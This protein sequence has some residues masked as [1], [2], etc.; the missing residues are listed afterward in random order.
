M[1]LT[2]FHTLKAIVDEREKAKELKDCYMRIRQKVE[3]P[4]AFDLKPIEEFMGYMNVGK[5]KESKNK[6]KDDTDTEDYEMGGSGG[7]GSSSSTI[8]SKDKTRFDFV[9]KNVKSIARRYSY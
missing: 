2:S 3:G 7:S 9:P 4:L 8:S 1:D 6:K 5:R